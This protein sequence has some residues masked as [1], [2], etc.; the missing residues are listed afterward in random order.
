MKVYIRNNIKEGKEKIMP[1]TKFIELV[2]SIGDDVYINV[3]AICAFY[4]SIDKK[5]TIVQFIG[6]PDNYINVKETPK[7][8]MNMIVDIPT[9][10]NV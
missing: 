10:I 5:S 4:R 9:V 2:D 6:S 8:I 1:H 7:E 3:D